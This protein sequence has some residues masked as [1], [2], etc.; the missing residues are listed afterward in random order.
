MVW[1]STASSEAGVVSSPATKASTGA[2]VTRQTAATWIPVRSAL[3]HTGWRETKVE[4]ANVQIR[5]STG[6][7]RSRHQVACLHRTLMTGGTRVAGHVEHRR[8]HRVLLLV[9]L[10]RWVPGNTVVTITATAGARRVP[11]NNCLARSNKSRAED[12]ATIRCAAVLVSAAAFRGE[13]WSHL[14][15]P[16]LLRAGSDSCGK[17]PLPSYASAPSLLFISR[18]RAVLI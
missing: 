5:M 9:P 8:A 14:S 3:L 17:C 16:T 13:S 2:P 15:H 4:N 11:T 7:A 18:H 12:N 10:V 6:V 1:A